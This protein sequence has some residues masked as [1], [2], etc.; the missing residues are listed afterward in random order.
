[1]SEI[2]AAMSEDIEKPYSSW[3]KPKVLSGFTIILIFSVVSIVITYKGFWDL[4]ITRQGLS[5]PGQKLALIN[6]IITDIYGEEADIRTY[7]LTSD[8]SYLER[9]SVK[10]KR[11]GKAL[12]SLERYTSNEDDQ[13]EKVK[14]I[15]TLLKSKRDI[16]NELVALRQGENSEKFYE[17][18]LRQISD[19]GNSVQKSTAIAKTTTVTTSQHDTLVA[20]KSDKGIFGKIKSF[21][22]GS[23][24]VDSLATNVKVETRHDTIPYG[25]YVPDSVINGL[26]DILNRIRVEQRKYR[27]NLSEM[28]LLL[29]DRDRDIMERIRSVIGALEKQELTSSLRQS[30]E[31]QNLVGKSIIKVLALG[32]IAFVLLIL[33]LAIIF[34]D[35]SQSN[36]YRIQLFE[37]KQYAE[38]LLKVKEQFL[39]NMSHEIRTPLSA[40]IGLTRQLQKTELAEK[41]QNY[42][43]T[44]SSSADH[45]LSVINDILDYSKL[46]SGQLKL[47]N[48]RFEPQRVISDVVT[49]FTPRASEKS[50]NLLVNI[51]S[52]VPLE[53]W[54]D[55][56]RL[57]QILMNLLSN[58]L[59]FT[60]SGSIIVS[61]A[62]IRQ[63]DEFAKL[64]ITVADSGVGIPEEQQ[65]QI[66]EEFTQADGGVARKYGGTGL[67][68]TIVKKLTELQG[69]EVTLVSTPQEGTTVKIVIPYRLQGNP[70]EIKPSLVD[71]SIPANTRILVIDDD[72]VNRLIVVEMAKSI[73]L[74]VDSIANAEKIEELIDQNDYKAI[75]TDIQMPGISGYDVVKIVEKFDSKV[76][77][78]AITANSM[79]DNLEHY[80]SMGF[81]GYLIKPFIED[82]LFNALAPLVGADKRTKTDVPKVKKSKRPIEQ[83]DLS[84][85]YRFAGGDNN[86]VRLILSS[87]LDNTYRNVD[88]LNKYVKAKDLVK[89]SAVAHKMKSAF[90]QFKIYHIAGLLQKIELLDPSKQRAASVYTEELNRQ[91]KPIIKDI[92]SRIESL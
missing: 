49:F 22:V 84:D 83:I 51:D 89:A 35:I 90:N 13:S 58:A 74:I 63:T 33:L 86:S 2:N 37:A 21:F 1:M 19:A 11:I 82:D 91:I 57:R 50:L 53:L 48:I 20:K 40:I 23:E 5:E 42:V 29:L 41:Q 76:P 54:G 34:R 8:T 45:L 77:V 16:V 9:Y 73:G 25:S 88:D 38:R 87:F 17:E 79:I 67:G 4:S 71:Y 43:S 46:E 14:Q 68:L 3:I 15:S 56:F 75:L 39:A 64:Q 12:K 36:Q 92:T 60:E 18:A 59:K 52:S 78:I 65:A 7:V 44:L 6:A 24:G 80:S 47:E 27:V 10:Q 31:V 55:T 32:A 69:G 85:I 81:S 62:I 70:E 28:E 26:V 30:L 72:E 61:G 66:F